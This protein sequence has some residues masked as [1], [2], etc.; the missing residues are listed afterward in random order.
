M[1]ELLFFSV[2]FLKKKIA[3][4]KKKVEAISKAA[5]FD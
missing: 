2:M 4:A 5:A 1:K 3:K